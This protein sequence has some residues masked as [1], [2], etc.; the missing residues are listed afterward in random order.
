MSSNR[1]NGV[2]FAIRIGF[3]LESATRTAGTDYLTVMVYSIRDY[4]NRFSSQKPVDVK[5]NT[6][7]SL[8]E[9]DGN[10]VQRVFLARHLGRLS[11]SQREA[12]EKLYKSKRRYG[13]W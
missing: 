6:I 10:P 3:Q 1:T 4:T 13:I 12:F 11:K 5:A 8:E 2:Y 9:I 7:V